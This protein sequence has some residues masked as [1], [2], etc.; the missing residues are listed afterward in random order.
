MGML[1][2]APPA[3]RWVFA[4]AASNGANSIWEHSLLDPGAEAAR[5]KTAPKTKSSESGV[6]GQGL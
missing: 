6:R 2:L 5:R 1:T 4:A 3:Y